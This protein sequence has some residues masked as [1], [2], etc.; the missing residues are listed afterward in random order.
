MASNNTGVYSPYD[1]TV[2][3]SQGTMSHVLAGYAEDSM[4]EVERAKDTFMLYS[5]AD[6][7]SSFIHSPNTSGTMTIHLQQ[8]SASNDILTELYHKASELRSIDGLFSVMIKDNS[9][10][11]VVFSS[12]A[13]IGKLPQVSYGASMQIR[14]WQ[15]VLASTDYTIGGNGKIS[16]ED[17]A[18][19]ES[20]GG[21]VDTRWL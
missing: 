4:I 1:V 21:T 5:G 9:G 19:I 8:T 3:I 11:T 12:E 20:L 2:T 17:A 16:P 18:A 7:V 15:I 10:R 13:I 6:N 14:D